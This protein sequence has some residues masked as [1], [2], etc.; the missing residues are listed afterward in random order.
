MILN[1]QAD[2]A[3]PELDEPVCCT[4]SLRE[5]KPTKYWQSHYEIPDLVGIST[6]D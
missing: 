3:L 6:M 1:P 4:N 2:I 5:Q